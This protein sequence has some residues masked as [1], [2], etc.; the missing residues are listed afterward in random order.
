MGLFV[1]AAVI[2]G[3]GAESAKAEG[4]NITITSLKGGEKWKVGEARTIKWK[5]ENI[6]KVGIYIYD[7]RIEGSGSTNYIT[8]NGALINAS[9]GSYKW[10]IKLNQLPGN[11]SGKKMNNFKIRIVG[12][13]V[14]GNEVFTKWSKGKITIKKK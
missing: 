2:F 1:F 10:K 4:E 3:A 6:D 12:Y 7:S 14:D 8:T 9:K 11:Y 13:D 5:A